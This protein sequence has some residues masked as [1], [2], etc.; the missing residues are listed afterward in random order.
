MFGDAAGAPQAGDQRSV[1]CF[2]TVASFLNGSGFQAMRDDLRRSTDEIFVIDCSP[3]GYQ[4]AVA[5]RVFQGVQQPVC[6]VLAVRSG[7][8]DPA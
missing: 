4:P 1:V 7:A 3:E 2:I 8:P 6:I 5:V